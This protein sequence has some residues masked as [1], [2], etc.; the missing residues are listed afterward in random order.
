VIGYNNAVDAS[1]P[2]AEAVVGAAKMAIQA[3]NNSLR[4]LF[5]ASVQLIERTTRG[6]AL[7][8]QDS[9]EFNYD[10]FVRAIGTQAT[11]TIKYGKKLALNQFAIKVE[12]LPDDE[13]KMYLDQLIVRGLELGTLTT[14]DAILLRQE[15]KQDVKLAAQLMIY[16]ENK[17]R[18]NRLAEEK[19]KVDYNT[20]QQVQSGQAVAQSNMESEQ[21]IAQRKDQ[22]L[23][24]EY[25]LKDQLGEKEHQRALE[26]EKLKGVNQ[27]A[28]ADVT[29]DH[30]VRQSAL[31]NSF[32]AGKEKTL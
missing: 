8:I 28:V 27:I 20:Q 13:E 25:T 6:I 4:P 12:L 22:S 26:L 17:N 29:H 7:M 31:D 15:M 2:D 24:L 30:S 11:E 1:S 5:Q 23:I 19:A 32:S 10:A 18:K 9:I 16:L 21:A 3:T 14:S